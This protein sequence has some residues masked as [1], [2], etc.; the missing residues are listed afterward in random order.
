V[1]KQE[2]FISHHPLNKQ[3]QQMTKP[4]QTLAFT[5]MHGLGNDFVVINTLSQPVDI[6][7]LNIPAL[8]HRHTGIGFDQALVIEASHD[9]TYFVRIFNSDGSEAEQCGN[10][11][12]CIA[13]YVHEEGMHPSSELTLATK[14]GVFP[15][16]INDYDHIRIEMGIPQ[17][18]NKQFSLKLNNNNLINV[19][20]ISLGNPH[21]IIKVNDTETGLFERLAPQVATHTHYTSGTNV[22][23]MTIVDSHHLKLRTLERGAGETSACGSNACAAAVAGI[24]NQWLQHHVRV[25]FQAGSLFIEWRGENSPVYMTGPAARIFDGQF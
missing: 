22:G 15:A 2:N 4:N 5:K 8:A 3:T 11:L 23:C 12:R 24:I 17:I 10:G 20:N 25:E 1:V 6:N 16:N 19:T 9:A 7:K 18:I 21:T 14:A 13:R